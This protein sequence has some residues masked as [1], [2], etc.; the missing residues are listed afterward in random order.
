MVSVV[1]RGIVCDVMG[2]GVLG[3]LGV[4]MGGD[5]RDRNELSVSENTRSR[6]HYALR[7]RR[8]KGE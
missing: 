3:V 5:A 7:Q 6:H 2:G 1:V 4:V 8:T